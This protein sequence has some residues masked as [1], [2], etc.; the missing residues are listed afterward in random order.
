MT[1]QTQLRKCYQI[2]HLSK[3][4]SKTTKCSAGVVITRLFSSTFSYNSKIPDRKPASVLENISNK[5]NEFSIDNIEEHS[6]NK[7]NIKS[8]YDFALNL[9]K[10]EPKKNSLESAEIERPDKAVLRFLKSSIISKPSSHKLA[11]IIR[12]NI[13]YADSKLVIFNKPYGIASHG[14]DKVEANVKEVLPMVSKMLHGIK[15]DFPLYLCHR[16]GTNVSGIMVCSQD[17]KYAKKLVKLFR[18]QQ[19]LKCFWAV[20]LNQPVPPIGKIDIPLITKT[21]KKTNR[22]RSFSKVRCSPYSR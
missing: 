6:L 20:T 3:P 11:R 22:N 8:A 4:I 16:L 18:E 13:I 12:K 14:G 1:H 21:I 15:T 17:E 5:F 7:N 9:R 2:F 10:E 19:I